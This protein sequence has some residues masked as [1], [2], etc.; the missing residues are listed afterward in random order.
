[1]SLNS[2]MKKIGG[3][4][5]YRKGVNLIRKGRALPPSLP[6]YRQVGIRS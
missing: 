6:A 5:E 4:S 3:V 1:M 2:P